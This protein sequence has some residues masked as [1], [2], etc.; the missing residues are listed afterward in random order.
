MVPDSVETKAIRWQAPELLESDM[1]EDATCIQQGTLATDVWAFG[2]TVIEVLY[3][4]LL[5]RASSAVDSL[6]K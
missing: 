3:Y 2:M 4:N 1:E 6:I 5:S